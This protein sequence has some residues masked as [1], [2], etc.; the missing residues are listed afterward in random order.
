LPAG[1]IDELVFMKL[2]TWRPPRARKLL[3]RHRTLLLATIVGG[4]TF[5]TCALVLGL[6]TPTVTRLALLGAVLGVVVESDLSERRIPN[7]IV[8]PAVI[9]FG[10]AW[11]ANGMKR[12]IVDGLV[13]VFVLL[14]ASLVP[15]IALGMGDVK[16]ALV[17]V[18]GLDGQGQL[19]VLLGLA[20]ATGF[21]LLLVLRRGWAGMSQQLP[22]APFV[23]A[24][25]LITVFM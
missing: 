4:I 2:G 12:S 22:L 16:L 10:A 7:R 17:V 3:R 13:V 15:R 1:T 19:A 6:S 18:L 25:A 9:V 5:A 24:G 8:V 11:V 23:A 14:V 21:G 20:L